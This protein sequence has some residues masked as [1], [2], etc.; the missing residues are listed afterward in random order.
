MKK[1]GFNASRIATILLAFLLA[2]GLAIPVAN[3]NMTGVYAAGTEVGSWDELESAI[4]NAS[5]G[6]T[7]TIRKNIVVNNNKP[8]TVSKAVTIT[9][10]NVSIYQG[11]PNNN[12]KY[13]TMFT[14]KKDGNLTIDSGVT[15]S[16][17]KSTDGSSGQCPDGTSYTADKFTGKYEEGKTTYTPK[18]FFIDVE[19]G[20]TATLNGTIS[21]FVTSRNKES[22]PR[23]VAPVVANGTGATFN[24]GAD[25]VIK[26]NLVGYIVDD[27]MAYTDAQTIKQYVKGAPPNS[28]RVPGSA[29]QKSHPD[30]YERTRNTNAGID[31]NADEDLGSGITGTAGAVIYKDGAQ[32]EILGK[33]DNNRGDTGG[34]MASGDGTVVHIKGGTKITRNV[35]VQ[36]GGGSTTEQGAMIAMHSGTMKQNVAWFG[37]GAVYATENGVDWLLGKIVKADG[38]PD[39]DARKDGKFTMKNGSLEENTAFTRGG[40]ILVDSDGVTVKSGKLKNNM[41]WMLGGAVYVMGDHP[42]YTYTMRI[43]PVYVHDNTAVSGLKEARDQ[44]TKLKEGQDLEADNAKLQRKL[45]APSDCADISETDD[46]FTAGR[47]KDNTDDTTDGKGNDGTGGGVWLCP[48]GSVFFDAEKTGNVVI[49]SNYATGTTKNSANNADAKYNSNLSKNYSHSGI[50]GGSDLHTDQGK[51]DGGVTISGLPL[52][53]WINENNDQPYLTET[54]SNRT[55]LVNTREPQAGDV[56]YKYGDDDY[57]EVTGNIARRGGGLASDG[58][59]YFGPAPSLA[60]INAKMT[61]GKEWTAAAKTEPIAIRVSVKKD[62]VEHSVEHSVERVVADVPLDGV[63]NGP[64]SEFDTVSELKPVG[65]LWT[66]EFSLPLVVTDDNGNNPIQLYELYYGDEFIDITKMSGRE[67]LGELVKTEKQGDIEIRQ[68]K[69]VE[70]I[71]KEMN[72]KRDD[73]GNWVVDGEHGTHVFTP[74]SVDFSKLKFTVEEKDE[75]TEEYLDKN[76]QLVTKPAYGIY[77]LGLALKMESGN[78]NEPIVEKYVNKKVHADI[79]NFD[80]DFTYDVM[81]YVPYKAT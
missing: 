78:D 43:D 9:G 33:I 45:A 1:Y 71:Y 25:G 61:V 8:I 77:T 52:G 56:P 21:D 66:G 2:T 32:G 47:I 49:N 6:D 12:G 76:G 48:Y 30:K 24:L 55:N 60:G 27:D 80:Q 18:G 68:A 35:G 57:V 26:N 39:F 46:L 17:K 72:V 28:L 53:G 69:D 59:F 74:D 38:K 4:S 64:V 15:L 11:N 58:K 22:T 13:Q 70:I 3:M 19:A 29:E 75:V 54:S 40:A 31:G 10:T 50:S 51:Q 67:R 7:I 73:G 16:A 20:G 63:A 62:S 41:S 79:V 36:F 37:G 5:D 65:N 81:A 44:V 42:K 14:V 23:Y 34:V